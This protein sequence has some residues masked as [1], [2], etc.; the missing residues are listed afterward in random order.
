MNAPSVVLLDYGSGNLR[1]AHRALERVGAE[2]SVTADFDLANG[3]VMYE[4]FIVQPKEVEAANEL[5]EAQQ[6]FQK[7]VDGVK[8]DR[9]PRILFSRG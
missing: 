9:D 1:S 4:K 8:S 7:A 5:F 3:Y 6:N 2:V